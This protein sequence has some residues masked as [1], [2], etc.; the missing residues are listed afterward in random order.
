[1]T[2]TNET[3]DSV[4]GAAVPTLSES[5]AAFTADLCLDRVPENVV[6]YCPVPSYSPRFIPF[7]VP[8]W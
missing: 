4:E 7:N 1:M 5:L 8:N 6:G 2:M 3:A